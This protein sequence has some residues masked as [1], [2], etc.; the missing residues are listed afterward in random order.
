MSPFWHQVLI[1]T[2]ASA[3]VSSTPSWDLMQVHESFVIR[4]CAASFIVG[5]VYICMLMVL[6]ETISMLFKCKNDLKSVTSKCKK[7]QMAKEF[8]DDTPSC[9]W[10][11]ASNRSCSWTWRRWLDLSWSSQGCHVLSNSGHLWSVYVTVVHVGSFINFIEV[12]VACFRQR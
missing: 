3:T 10:E 5:A 7:M 2:C 9:Q 8:S 1:H 6:I 4:Y 11:V 12:R